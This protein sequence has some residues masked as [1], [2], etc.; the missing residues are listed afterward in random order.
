MRVAHR[1][2]PR[3]L[4]AEDHLSFYATRFDTVEIDSSYY[5]PPAAATVD[6]WYRKTPAGF[7][8]TVKV[9]QVVTH[10]KVLV[11]CEAEFMHFLKTMEGLREKLGPLLFQFGHF[12]P[13]EFKDGSE[14]LSLLG[15][16]FENLPEGFKFAVEIRNKEWIGAPFLDLLRKH[17]VAFTLTDLARMPRPWEMNSGL[18]R[19]TADFTYVRWL[20]YRHA[21]EAKTKT[22]NKPIEDREG[23]LFEWVK[24]LKK[25]RERRIMVLAFAN[26]HHAGYGPGTLDLFRGSREMRD[27]LRQSPSNLH[28]STLK[29]ENLTRV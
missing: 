14:F 1:H 26:N 23:E 21:I 12:Y 5:G 18:D 28:C 22:W 25:V 10:E 24:E 9:P 4:K 13:S 3:G 6:G 20:G 11:N 29:R 7:L 27:F 16:F 15:S 2:G 19:I 17:K 8:F